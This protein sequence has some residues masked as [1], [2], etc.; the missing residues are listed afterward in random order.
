MADQGIDAGT[1]APAK[2]H[3]RFWHWGLGVVTALILLGF[4]APFF[5]LVKGRGRILAALQAALGRSVQAQSVHLVLIPWPGFELDQLQVADAP[6]Y[7]YQPIIRAAEATA[8]LRLAAL[9]KGRFEFPAS[10]S[11]NPI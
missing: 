7:G 4:S 11:T 3:R 10:S 1:R 5:T 9:W 6:A 8:T 2:A